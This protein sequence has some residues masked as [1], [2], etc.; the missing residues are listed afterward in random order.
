MFMIFRLHDI[1]GGFMA[2]NNDD[3]TTSRGLWRYAKE[4]HEAA[5]VVDN[6]KGKAVISTPAYYLEVPIN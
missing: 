3:R 1:G 6:F 5:K 2:Q 4:F